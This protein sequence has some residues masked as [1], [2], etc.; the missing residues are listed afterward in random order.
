MAKVTAPLMSMDAS[1]AFGD[2]IVYA[3]WKGINYARQYVVPANPRT[4]AQVTTRTYFN[5]AVE[6]WHAEDDATRARWVDAARGLPLT[7][8]NLY[9]GKYVQYLRGHEG[10]AP[11]APFLPPS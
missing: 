2:T 10:Q 8:F 5:Q 6:A 9:V 7:G 3:K 4:Q 11:A 1:G